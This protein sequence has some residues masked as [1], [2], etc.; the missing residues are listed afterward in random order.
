MTMVRALAAFLIVGSL[1]T[2]APASA[3]TGAGGLN[4][5]VKDEQGGVLPGV[6]VTAKSSEL[7]APV[8]GVTD[9]GGYYRLNNLPPGI[10]SI[11]AELPGFGSFQRDGILMRAGSTFTVD[12][13]LKVGGLQE[14]ITVSGDSPMIETG[15]PATILNVS[16]DLLRAA[17]VTARRLWSDVLD[18]A[19]GINSRNVDNA[20]GTRAYYF[21]GTTLF[22]GVYQLEGAPLATY[23]DA[24]AQSVGMGGDTVADAEV[25][26]GGVDAASPSGTGAVMNIIAPRGGN[27]FK[28]SLA[29]NR[30]PTSWASDNTQNGRVQGG[31]P[32][33]QGVKQ[34]DASLGGPLKRDTV[35]FFTS[36]RYADLLNGISRNPTDLGFLRTFR[37]DFQPFDNG[38]TSKQPFVK[39]TAQVNPKHELTGFYQ[40]DR[41]R[42]TS[43][44]ERDLDQVSFGAAGGSLMQGRLQTVWTNRVTTQISASYNNKGGNDLVTFE[45]ARGS[46][47]Q[48]YIHQDAFLSRGIPTGSG[49]LVQGGN[50][51]SVA[52]S[53]A[54]MAIVR[55]DLTYF[56]DG[57][58]GSHEFKAGVWLAPRL[59]RDQTTRYVN[60]GFVL[61]EQRQIDP[62]NPAA[63]VVAFH[64]QYQSPT[65]ALTLSTRD[66]AYSFY[67]Q[68]SWRPQSRLT[69]N[70][71]VRVDYVRRHD[72]IFNIDRMKATHVA[73]R[74]GASYLVTQDAKNVL[75]ASYSRIYEQVNGRDYV[76]TFAAGTPR[77][78]ALLDQYDV[79]GDG[80]FEISVP[81]PIA[82][83]DL[84]G[85][86]FNPDLHQP[87]TD[88]FIVG[89]SRQ[90]PGQ[91][92][93]NV[94]GT[95]RYMKHGYTLVDINGRYPSGPNQPFGGFGLVD[96]NRGIINQEN[97][98]EWATVVLDFL[99]A[100]V[101]KN[102]SRNIQGTLSLTR[103]WQRITGT[104]GPTDP[105]RFISPDAFPNNR[106]LAAYLF[107]NGDAN[108]LSGGGREAGVAYRPYSVRAAVQYLAPW[109]LRVGASYVI[110][111][112]GWVGNLVTRI[113]T[114]DP[115]FG[116]A[117]LTLPNGTTQPNPLATTIR[118]AYPTRGEGQIRNEDERYLQL[119]L[120]RE[121]N[122]GGHRLETALGVFNVFNSGAQQ[123]WLTGANQQYS[124][125]YLATF[126][127]T[128]PRQFQMTF[129]YRF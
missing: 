74:A 39:L 34:W 87:F 29:F 107:G 84:S 37:P 63:G 18:M 19:P 57:W 97:N 124:A 108:T 56:R 30:Q 53:P 115:R 91:F 24:G 55:G 85:V 12:I 114:A 61:E 43:G 80:R 120:G 21:H 83:T 69:S 36:F 98:R 78:S 60:D 3:Q 15:S 10:F 1:S 50:V 79:D 96:P 77:G 48:I 93:V 26:L 129:T 58:F 127:R 112:G 125:N 126:S 42:S 117:T 100:V 14:S 71:G 62:A 92:A 94:N 64:R 23:N 99:E 102:M 51:Q 75:R 81:T 88:E 106:E 116:P 32:T 110:Q 11:S 103:Q 6:T 45:A 49:I 123:Q 41:R 59:A 89:F 90:F 22:H 72:E 105:S 111:S 119:Q 122:I 118:F 13:E 68:D 33:V 38:S 40:Y 25:K 76:T 8:V 2:S 16:G 95:R 47:P 67:V 44:R 121:F 46:G 9:S 101:A 128:S 35:W 20:S 27:Q 73:P 31:L 82:T 104:W 66:R 86:E 70:L 109:H 52:L 5:F 113:P 7:L 28:G 17:P 4:G 54:S 65:E